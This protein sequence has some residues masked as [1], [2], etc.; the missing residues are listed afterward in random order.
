MYVAPDPATLESYMK[1]HEVPTVKW[2]KEVWFEKTAIYST[3][4]ELLVAGAKVKRKI[5]MDATYKVMSRMGVVL[6]GSRSLVRLPALRLLLLA[7]NEIGQIIYWS[8]ISSENSGEL[9][10]ALKSILLNNLDIPN[11]PNLFSTYLVADENV[12]VPGYMDIQQGQAIQE[13]VDDTV[14]EIMEE[15]TPED[16]E[17]EEGGE[18]NEAEFNDFEAM[19]EQNSIDLDEVFDVGWK[20][21]LVQLRVFLVNISFLPIFYFHL[22]IWLRRI[23]WHALIM[24]KQHARC[25]Q[26][27]LVNGE[28]DEICPDVLTCCFFL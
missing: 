8:P 1:D 11:I 21:F 9:K 27:H 15:C 6:K 22:S 12:H 18:V 19:D 2:L 4:C 13:I 3:L 28:F 10:L 26:N 17:E 14:G 5:A 20:Q 7:I 16:E 24:W 23:C 25:L